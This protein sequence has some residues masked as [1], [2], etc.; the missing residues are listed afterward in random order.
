MVDNKYSRW[1]IINVNVEIKVSPEPRYSKFLSD[2]LKNRKGIRMIMM[3][4]AS[5]H[6]LL[7]VIKLLTHIRHS[8]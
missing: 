6:I 7:L 1:L 5:L 3:I 2:I 4:D 8:H